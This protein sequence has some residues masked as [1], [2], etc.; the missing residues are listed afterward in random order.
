MKKKQQLKFRRTHPEIFDLKKLS[1]QRRLDSLIKSKKLLNI[2]DNFYEQEKELFE[3]QNPNLIFSKAFTANFQKFLKKREKKTPKKQRGKWIYFPWN[4]SLV[5]ILE[6][7]EFFLVRTARNQLLITPQEQKKFYF[8]NIGIAGLSVGSSIALAIVLQGGGRHLKLADYDLLALSN[9]NR[10]K[11]GIHEL[12]ELKTHITARQIYEINP[13]AKIE[14]FNEGL[15][16]KNLKQFFKGL[17]VMID[18]I[19][20][21]EVKFL[22]RQYSAKN[23]L[24]VLMA[25]DNADSGVIDIERYDLNPKLKFFHGRLGKINYAKLSNL[26][27]LE[28]GRLITKLVGKE[29]ISQRMHISLSEIGKSIVSWPQLGGT[30]MLNGAAVAYCARKIL[31]GQ[32]LE[33]NRA[34]ISLDEKLSNA[35]NTKPSAGKRS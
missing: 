33:S 35:Y 22:I 34:I 13:Y 5:H 8:S 32:P 30:A 19:D 26:D 3:I 23:K 18:E 6:E 29:N 1:Q 28:T 17:D 12:G 27:K 14:L 25:A 31:N 24:P 2:T 11:T 4:G 16:K 10:I 7:K 21:L 15:N 9:T 20:N